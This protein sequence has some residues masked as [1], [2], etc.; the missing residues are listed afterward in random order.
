MGSTSQYQVSF[1]ILFLLAA[2]VAR[3]RVT[4]SF[5]NNNN[6]NNNNNF[7]STIRNNYVYL[8]MLLVRQLCMHSVVELSEC[9]V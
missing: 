8:K 3:A 7:L 6:N 9:C 4:L 1:G 5:D 2:K